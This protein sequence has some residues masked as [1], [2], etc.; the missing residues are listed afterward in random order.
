MNEIVEYIITRGDEP[1]SA[2]N[3][4][5]IFGCPDVTIRRF[6]NQARLEG[7]PI[8]S[9]G[10]GYYYSNS[11]EDINRTIASLMHRITSIQNAVNGLAS[12]L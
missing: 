5:K 10:K 8:C 11:K 3:L 1:I 9:C 7:Y 2:K 6:I 12:N 4:S